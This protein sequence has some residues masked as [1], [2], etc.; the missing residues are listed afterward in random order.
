M[1]LGT[2]MLLLAQGCTH[3]GQGSEHQ[4]GVGTKKALHERRSRT[5]LLL[6]R[7]APEASKAAQLACQS[8]ERSVASVSADGDLEAGHTAGAGSN[9]S[10]M[11]P[12]GAAAQQM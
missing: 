2:M 3:R 7:D 5:T 1:V 8:A 11:P 4:D 9:K 6:P 10:L 12:L